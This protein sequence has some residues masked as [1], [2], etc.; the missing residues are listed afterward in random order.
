MSHGNF[1][2]KD[3]VNTIITVLMSIDKGLLE[4]EI[5]R[6]IAPYFNINKLN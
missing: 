4:T 2:G 3:D 6:Y 5:N 1:N